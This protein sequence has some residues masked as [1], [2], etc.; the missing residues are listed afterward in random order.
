[1][2][3]INARFLTQPI[4]GVQRFSIELSKRLS[5][6]DYVR[7]VAPKNILHHDL[8]EYL[9]V[10][11]CGTNTGQLWE[12]WELPK[13]LMSKGNPLLINFANT[14]PLFY[15]NKILTIHDLAFLVNPSWFSLKFRLF[16]KF[17]VPRAAKR[18]LLIFTVSNYIKSEIL[19]K[20]KVHENKVKVIYNGVGDA[21]LK[22]IR[23][24]KNRSNNKYL[25]SVA[26][27]DPRKNLITLVRAFR[28]LPDE[29][30][31]LYLVGGSHN[32][33]SNNNLRHEIKKDSRIFMMGRVT[34]DD[35]LNLYQ[36]AELFIY[37]SLYEGFG[38]PIIE[39]MSQGVPV[40]VSDIEV[41]KEVCGNAAY[42]FSP[43]NTMD[44]KKG[45]QC[46]LKDQNKRAELIM[47]GK[48]RCKLFTWESSLETLYFHLKAFGK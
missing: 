47:Q 48:I 8:A 4:T 25:L 10:E 29:N 45:I 43:Y 36:N 30:I 31:R 35:L 26:S 28:E 1:M 7:F 16:Y 39:A 13:Y 23:S 37:P 38:I 32:S 17:L 33:F 11:I 5:E 20:L 22:D 44:L 6:L 19:E 34:D 41:F 9:K 2:I 24:N 42:Y 18:A 14:A 27:Q 40:L 46:L 21:F 3:Y 15:K 12:Q